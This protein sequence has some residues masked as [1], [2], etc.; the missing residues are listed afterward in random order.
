MDKDKQSEISYVLSLEYDSIY[1]ID[2][3]KGTFKIERA[4]G[5]ISEQV[6]K[7]MS[8]F[9]SYSEGIESYISAYVAPEDKE[10]VRD[11]TKIEKVCERLK[12]ERAFSVRYRRIVNDVTEYVKWRYIR[13]LSQT[14]IILAVRNVDGEMA[15]EIQQKALLENALNQAQSANQ[16]KTN[17]LSNMS[18]DIR[19]PMNAIIG[20]S[21]IAM[22]HSGDEKKVRDCLKKILSSSNHLLNLINDILDMSRIESGRVEMQEEKCNL[23]EMLHNLVQMIQPQIQTKRLEFFINTYNVINE[24]VITD[25]LK[26]NQVF[27]NILS[28]AVKFTP[29]GGI[30]TFGIYQ[31]PSDLTGYG[32]YKFV[33]KDTGVGM[34][35][36]FLEHIFEPF[37]REESCIQSGIEGTGLGM[38][39]AKNMVD[40]LG[41][42]IQVKSKKGKGSKFTIKLPIRLTT[43]Q[44]VRGP[45]KG[46]AGIKVLVVDDDFDT[47]DNTTRML[48]QMGIRSEWTTSA[49]E[50]VFRAQKAY[51]EKDAFQTYIINWKMPDMDG[52]EATKKI[53]KIIGKDVPIIILTVNDWTEEE[54]YAKKAGVT[55]FCSKPLF[56][57]DL[58]SVLLRVNHLKEKEKVQEISVKKQYEGKR[59]LVVED[60]ALN[61]EIAY[62]I[63]KE[64]GFLVEGAENGSVAVKM[65]KQSEEGWY[66]LVL[67]DVRMPVMNGYEATTAIRNLSRGDIKTMPIIAMTANAFEEDREMALQSG[68]NAHIAKPLNIE[69]LF[70]IL[71]D[72]V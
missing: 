42:T 54:D 69:N 3:E 14:E 12:T 2:V 13:G 24:D 49:K 53:R 45:I 30:I 63:L 43:D 52:I 56:W 48:T 28:N 35:R 71:S 50:A 34:S 47:C 62:E 22:R 9:P 18:H 70:A 29:S 33:I 55:T 41:G 39:I 59:V 11:E 31:E 36:K 38:S 7:L 40:M 1:V 4:S 61:R 46:L 58:E 15:R 65:I 37:E 32:V 68:M 21:E 10:F 26:L 17:F 67:M 8:G 27:I 6:A 16:A 19:T 23:S 72:Y 25:S 51:E 44:K 60:N 20:F 64:A 57:S 66:H 5:V